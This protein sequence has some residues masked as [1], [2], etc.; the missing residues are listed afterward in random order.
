[1]AAVAP[2]DLEVYPLTEMDLQCLMLKGVSTVTYFKGDAAMAAAFMRTRLAA[3]LEHNPWL[4]GRL[5]KRKKMKKAHLEFPPA[6]D[7]TARNDAANSMVLLAEPSATFKY[8]CSF[9]DIDK[10]LNGTA[11]EVATG[12]SLVNKDRPMLIAAFVPEADAAEPAF[13]LS[14]S[15]SHATCDGHSY[16]EVLNMLSDGAEI[17]KLDARRSENDFFAD[18]RT[19]FGEDNMGYLLGKA[20]LYNFIT[21]IVFGKKKKLC[22]RTVDTTYI[23]KA[24]SEA[25]EEGVVPFVSTNDV[26]TSSFFKLC[27]CRNGHMAVNCRGRV[28]GCSADAAGNLECAIMYNPED[29]ATPVLIRQSLKNLRRAAVPESKF[30]GTWTRTRCRIALCTN[31]ATNAE[32]VRLPDCKHRVHFPYMDPGVVPVECAVVFKPREGETATLLFTSDD[33]S[34]TAA[35][36]MGPFGLPIDGLSA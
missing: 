14:V 12:S 21:T 36:E 6:P 24:K 8:G 32:E 29:F 17:K 15:L 10:A 9:K 33:L 34:K 22:V 23:E 20:L 3:V 28:P 11:L 5:V 7:A 13:A 1:M 30:P 2:T 4:M 25:K 27:K 35:T 19:A 16:Y 26:L 18:L 31:W